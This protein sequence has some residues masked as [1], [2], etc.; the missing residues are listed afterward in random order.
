M[1]PYL[2]FLAIAASIAAIAIRQREDQG[3]EAAW[4]PNSQVESDTESETEA[5]FI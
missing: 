1:K 4:A 3:Q 5:W 2:L